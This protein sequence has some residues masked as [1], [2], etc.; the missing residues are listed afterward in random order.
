MLSPVVNQPESPV[1]CTPTFS[2]PSYISEGD[3]RQPVGANLEETEEDSE[4]EESPSTPEHRICRSA[5]STLQSERRRLPDPI[6]PCSH[7][8]PALPGNEDSHHESAAV[9]QILIGCRLKERQRDANENL[10]DGAVASSMKSMVVDAIELDKAV[11][12]QSEESSANLLEA[13]GDD[14]PVERKQLAGEQT[15]ADEA[16]PIHHEKSAWKKFEDKEFEVES[17]MLAGTQ[18]TDGEVAPV[19]HEESSAVTPP[20]VTKAATVASEASAKPIQEPIEGHGTKAEEQFVANSPQPSTSKDDAEAEKI[21]SKILVTEM[22]TTTEVPREEPEKTSFIM[23]ASQKPTT[24]DT[25]KSLSP[26]YKSKLDQPWR[27]LSVSPPVASNPPPDSTTSKNWR[28]FGRSWPGRAQ[29][30]NLC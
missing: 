9:E 2:N 1:V 8:Q 22:H 28:V 24:D 23:T 4:G 25:V 14:E 21:L 19:L 5:P 18:D 20:R 26:K 29:D 12:V 11:Q 15:K 13:G 16:A 30:R 10:S 7:R 3:E 17:E 27:K 6:S